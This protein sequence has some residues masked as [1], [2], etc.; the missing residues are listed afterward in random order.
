MIRSIQTFGLIAKAADITTVFYKQ[1]NKRI[2]LKKNASKI[3]N[4]SMRYLPEGPW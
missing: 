1:I 4:E 2:H 3:K